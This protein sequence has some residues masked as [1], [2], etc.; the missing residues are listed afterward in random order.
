MSEHARCRVV[1]RSR[2]GSLVGWWRRSVVAGYPAKTS[3]QLLHLIPSSENLYFQVQGEEALATGAA[4]PG[5]AL[6]TKHEELVEVEECHPV[7]QMA[8]AL[9]AF[10][11]DSTLRL[12][13]PVDLEGHK[14]FADEVF[15]GCLHGGPAGDILRQVDMVNSQPSAAIA[16]LSGE[17]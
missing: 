16:W 4:G 7:V 12:W 3:S 5:S 17:G 15:D 13:T 1:D 10:F 6:V 9:H 8:V 14:A 2:S 11:I